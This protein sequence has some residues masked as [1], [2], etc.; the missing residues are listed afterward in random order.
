MKP[1][2]LRHRLEKSAKL[3]WQIQKHHAEA[4]THFNPERGEQGLVVID[5]EKM[6]QLPDWA[7][8]LGIDLESKGYVFTKTLNPWLGECTVRGRR[9]AQPDVIF[10]LAC[11]IDRSSV[12]G[13]TRNEPYSFK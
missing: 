1:R 6:L 4:T 8:K 10:Q 3:L 5:F 2:S 7:A 12:T 9:E 13:E 11:P